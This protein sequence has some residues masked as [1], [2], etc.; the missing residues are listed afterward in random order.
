[1]CIFSKYKD[2]FGKPNQGPHSYRFFNIAIV[3]FVLTIIAATLY[4]IIFN[5]SVFYSNLILFITAIVMHYLFGVN[6]TINTI[7]FGKL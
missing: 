5:K 3:D 7:I 4:A 1:M 6:T 2:I